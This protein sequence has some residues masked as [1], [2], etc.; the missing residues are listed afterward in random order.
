[1][2]SIGTILPAARARPHDDSGR[3]LD[4]YFGR[5]E[6]GRQSAG[7][8]L[9]LRRDRRRLGSQRFDRGGLPGQGRA[10]RCSCWSGAPSLAAPPSP[11]SVFPG[12][13]LS[14]CSY[15]CNLLLPEVI[16]DL[17]T[18]ATWLRRAAIRPPVLRPLPRRLLLHELPRREQ[19]ARADRQVLATRCGRLRCVLGDVGSHPGADAAAAAATGAYLGSDRGTLFR[20]AGSGRLADADPQEHRRA[21]GRVLRI[22]ADQGAAMHWRGDRRQR[23]SHDP[24]HRAM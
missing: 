2:P 20:P 13:R 8:R 9:P 21:S 24:R 4:D 1:M 11:K 10:K 3:N 7:G 16:A 18:H 12:Y 19:D 22:R 17:R 5:H 15:V 6:L 14:T 23:R